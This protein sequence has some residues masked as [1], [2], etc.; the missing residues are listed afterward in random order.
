[1]LVDSVEDKWLVRLLEKLVCEQLIIVLG[2]VVGWCV[3][4]FTWFILV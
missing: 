4:G 3:D 2:S 1:L